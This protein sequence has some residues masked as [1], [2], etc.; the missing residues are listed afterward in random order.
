MKYLLTLVLYVV[1]F[2]TYSQNKTPKTVEN[3]EITV[4]GL[5]KQYI[6]DFPQET[7]F[8]IATI[9]DDVVTY[10]GFKKNNETIIEIDN[11]NKLYEIGS[12]TKVFTSTLLAQE[13]INKKINLKDKINQHFPFTFHN[14]ASITF[15]N[16]ANHTSGLPRLPENLTRSSDNNPYK[17]YNNELLNEYLANKIKIDSSKINKI[18]Y[19]NLGAGLLGYTLALINNTTIQNLIQENIFSQYNMIQ[20]KTNVLSASSNLISG[21]DPNGNKINNWDWDVLF[22]AGGIISSVSDLQKFVIAHFNPTDK[23]LQLTQQ[24]TFTDTN[25]QQ[26]GLG[27]FIIKSKN[28]NQLLFH[29]GGTAGYTSSLSIDT[30]N[31]KAVIILSNVSAFH[32][33]SSS[34]DEL[35]LKIFENL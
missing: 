6:N 31:Q 24:T 12:I 1:N 34:I 19:S 4:D 8:A 28:N 16:L 17:N 35:N 15:L 5:I 20:S 14:N 13:V 32:Y 18:N 25:G 9:Q 10:Y 11:K 3:A 22:G 2:F 30:Q 27:W 23:A 21:L 7:E 33:K 26:T 29:N